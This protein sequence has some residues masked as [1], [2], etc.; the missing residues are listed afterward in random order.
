[1][2]KKLW[3]F[4][5]I[6]ANIF[7]QT[8]GFFLAAF[9]LFYRFFFPQIE[10]SHPL[11]KVFRK[12]FEQKKAQVFW[13]IGLL[14]LILSGQLFS[15]PFS[16]Q[17]QFEPEPVL[18]VSQEVIT[19]ETTFQKPTQGWFSQGFSWYHQAVDLGA[20]LGEKVYP[21]GSG[22]VITIK[23]SQW[24]YGHF[25]VVEH[26]MGLKSLYAHLGEIKVKP[27]QKIDKQTLLGFIGLTGYTTGPHLHLEVYGDEGYLN[28]VD[29]VPG[30]L[31]QFAYK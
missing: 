10:G 25:V 8:I 26:E 18:V 6:A 17:A 21:I 14:V 12:V 27:G 22:K 1:M 24:G 15:R 13:G 7:W 11:S 3:L 23:Y 20:P 4:L 19:T 31:P 29:L 5:S 30:I 16:V 9:Y 28:P 2:N